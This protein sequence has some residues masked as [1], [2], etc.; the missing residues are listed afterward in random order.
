VPVRSSRLATA[1]LALIVG[2]CAPTAVPGVDPPSAP[3]D[4]N[5]VATDG[6]DLWL[7]LP[8]WLVP[9]DNRQAIF[10]NEVVAGGGQGIQLLAEGPRTAEPQPA[11]GDTEA[12]LRTRIESPGSGPP[13]VDRVRLFAGD[14]VRIQRLDRAGTP[15]AWR[16]VGY[17]ITT[18]FGTAYLLIDGPPDAWGAREDDIARIPTLIR[19]GPGR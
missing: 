8:P 5:L 1:A 19:A 14:G 3:P 15:L 6:A 12:W 13:T 18:P 17:A 2:A 10:A 16:L 11:P 4:W 9:F 7:T